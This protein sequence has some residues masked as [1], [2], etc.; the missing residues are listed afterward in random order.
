MVCPKCGDKIPDGSIF[1]NMCGARILD[2]KV[3]KIENRQKKRV[4][5]HKNDL[6]KE[7]NQ[8]ISYFSKNTPQNNIISTIINRR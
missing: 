1:C 5:P 3:I 6:Q 2:D 4:K 7:L 8:I